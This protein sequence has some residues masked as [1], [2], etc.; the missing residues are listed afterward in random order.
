MG[1]HVAPTTNGRDDRGRFVLG[2]EGG[3]G[4]PHVANIAKLRA[5][6][7][8]AVDRTDIVDIFRC[9]VDIAK[10]TEEKS[11]ERVQAARFVAEYAIGKPQPAE[12]TIGS[13]TAGGLTIVINRE[14]EV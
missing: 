11:S 1:K 14:S 13:D 4:N 12:V 2:N 6:I 9:M 3:P 7:F 10:N 5:A 8:D